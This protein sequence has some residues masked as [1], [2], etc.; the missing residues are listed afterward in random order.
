M[1][2]A[3]DTKTPPIDIEPGLQVG[4]GLLPPFYSRYYT[5]YPRTFVDLQCRHARWLATLLDELDTSGLRYADRHSIIGIGITTP[6][7]R[8]V[9]HA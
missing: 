9:D 8:L 1:D 5:T 3:S 2:A 7:A 6:I 4:I